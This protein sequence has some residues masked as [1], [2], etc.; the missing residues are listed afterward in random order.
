MGPFILWCRLA[1]VQSH[2]A[3]TQGML[4]YIAKTIRQHLEDFKTLPAV[5]LLPDVSVRA[6]VTS[7]FLQDLV[8]LLGSAKQ[9]R[10]RS[11]NVDCGRWPRLTVCCIR[12]ILT[13][14][15]KVQ[16]V[17]LPLYLSAV[18]WHVCS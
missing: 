7:I 12:Q 5:H 9:L 3:Q 2:T 6:D 11:G 13:T 16:L 10:V 8:K 4:Q 15:L 1:K 17:L 14:G 18:W